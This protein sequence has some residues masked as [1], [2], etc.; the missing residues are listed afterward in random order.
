MYMSGAS[1]FLIGKALQ[2][3]LPAPYFATEKNMK[4][5]IFATALI[6]LSGCT[7]MTSQSDSAP[8]M[9]P[10]EG[11]SPAVTWQS[12]SKEYQLITTGIY[13]HARSTLMNKEVPAQN[14]V[15][16]F[17]VD[18]TL[19]DNSQYQREREEQQAGYS[20]ESWATWVEREEATAVPGAIAYVKAVLEKGGRLAL[21]TNRSRELDKHTWANLKAAGFPVTFDNACLTGRNASDKEAVTQGQFVND[22]DKRRFEISKGTAECYSPSGDASA[23]WSTPYKIIVQIGDNIEDIQSTLQDSADID[24]LVPQWGHD[25][26]ILPNPMYGS[27]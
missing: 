18:E 20:S 16:V 22:K 11:Y 24:A 12:E 23:N 13:E 1:L 6:S 26:V 14:W 5:I 8:A 3:C 19:L 17:D 15:V 4:H 10:F 2:C 27:W 9:A 7:A 21:I 25:I